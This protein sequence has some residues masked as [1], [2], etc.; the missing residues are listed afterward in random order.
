MILLLGQRERRQ[1]FTVGG[2]HVGALRDQRRDGVHVVVG[3]G[4]VQR[5]PARGVGGVDVRASAN[6]ESRDQL[7]IARQRRVQRRVAVRV[8]RSR[9]DIGA[10]REQQLDDL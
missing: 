5:L 9:R 8:A 3:G 4:Q 6:Q 7:E 10:L 2:R 1:P